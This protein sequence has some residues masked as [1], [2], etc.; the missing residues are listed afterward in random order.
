MKQPLENSEFRCV[1][2]AR[3]ALSTYKASGKNIDIIKAVKI[4]DRYDVWQCVFEE[5]KDAYR[6]LQIKELY[7]NLLKYKYTKK[8][9]RITSM[10]YI[11]ILLRLVEFKTPLKLEDGV[12]IVL[13][14]LGEKAIPHLKAEAKRNYEQRIEIIKPYF[15]HDVEWVAQSKKL[16]DVLDKY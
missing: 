2:A 6:E 12:A 10:L 7:D 3:S 15:K 13:D 8:L 14:G 4:I 1:H 16:I 5:E 11:T 9:A